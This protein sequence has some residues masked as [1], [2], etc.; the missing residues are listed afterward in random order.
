MKSIVNGILSGGKLFGSI[1]TLL[2]QVVT[3]DEERQQLE[4]KIQQVIQQH[5]KDLFEVEFEDRTLMRTRKS[6]ALKLVSCNVTQNILAYA[7]IGSFF[8]MTGYIIANGIG[9]LNT[10]E[11]F[12]IGNLTGMAAAIA[13]DIYGYY[14]GSSKGERDAG[15]FTKNT[16][17]KDAKLK[18]LK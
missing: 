5:E 7:A 6:G 14:F 17:R 3:T 4:L 2:E 8:S 15:K 16:F 12:I 9:T 1:K 13:K 11:S 18:R 10:E